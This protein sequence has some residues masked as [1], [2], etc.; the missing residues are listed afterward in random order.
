[1]F[2]NFAL[3]VVLILASAEGFSFGKFPYAAFVTPTV[4]RRPSSATTSATFLRRSQTNS[5]RSSSGQ[6][7]HVRSAGSDEAIGSS[8]SNSTLV[9]QHHQEQDSQSS[10]SKQRKGGYQRAEDWD[11]ELKAGGMSWDQKVQ[12]DGLRMGNGF[13]Q[14]EILRRHLSNF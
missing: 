8:F 10:Q 14:N 13:R 2:Y 12:F 7:L 3:F 1:M 9:S 4:H 6:K 11:A 5:W